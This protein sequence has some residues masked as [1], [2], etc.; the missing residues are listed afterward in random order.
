MSDR[1]AM[2]RA[3]RRDRIRHLN[4]KFRQSLTGGRVMM[5]PGISELGPIKLLAIIDLVRSYSAFDDGNDP[6]GEHDFGAFRIVAERLLWKI[7]Y[8]DL[9]L[10]AG[11]PDPADSTVTCRVLTIMRASE[12]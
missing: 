8:Y 11:S 3:Q 2:A 12:W 1:E 7:D 9:T 10:T 5:T 4:D 6:Y